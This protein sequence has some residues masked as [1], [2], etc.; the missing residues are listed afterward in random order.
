M[1][2]S[3]ADFNPPAVNATS[4]S[5]TGS[6]Q[7]V[8]AE[9]NTAPQLPPLPNATLSELVTLVVTNTATDS[10]LPANGLSYSLL[11]APAGA[12]ISTCGK[13]KYFAEEP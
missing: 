4:L 2:I 10:D 5:V 1:V 11:A 8:V 9:V 7:I 6:F 12:T 13:Q 3:V